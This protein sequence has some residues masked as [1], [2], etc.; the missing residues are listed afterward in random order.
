MKALN[1]AV[2]GVVEVRFWTYTQCNRALPFFVDS[3]T[4]SCTD[5]E[6]F[7]SENPAMAGHSL[8]E[9]LEFAKEKVPEKQWSRTR[10]YL[11]ATAGLRRLDK[12]VQ[13]AV[14]E[15]CRTVL[16]GST[17][18]FQDEWASVIS[19]IVLLPANRKYCVLS[20]CITILILVRAC[21]NSAF[22]ELRMRPSDSVW[23][24]PC[25]FGHYTP[26]GFYLCT[27]RVL[28]FQGTMNFV[29]SS[30]PREFLSLLCLS[31]ALPLL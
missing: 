28:V 16:H 3:D 6:V 23:Q 26:F 5:K 17:F 8:K 14:L 27:F 15:S 7:I 11:M 12:K 10:I 13:E 25:M 20:K 2:S 4:I 29:L 9:Q 31:R 18:L 21:L 19:G 1:L 22:E 30:F 24:G